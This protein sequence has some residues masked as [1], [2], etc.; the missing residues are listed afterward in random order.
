MRERERE[1]KRLAQQ[2]RGDGGGGRKELCKQL[3]NAFLAFLGFERTGEAM[4][5]HVAPVFSKCFSVIPNTQSTGKVAVCDAS[6]PC[7]PNHI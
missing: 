7:L 2:T 4:R 3:T 5:Q 6:L 1:G